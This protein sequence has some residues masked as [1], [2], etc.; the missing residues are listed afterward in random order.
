MV[1]SDSLR[2]SADWMLVEQSLTAIPAD[3]RAGVDRVAVGALDRAPDRALA[4]FDTVI[5]PA[6]ITTRDTPE[7][8]RRLESLVRDHNEN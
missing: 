8:H 3:T 7:I 5:T 4:I 6:G 1:E 2:F